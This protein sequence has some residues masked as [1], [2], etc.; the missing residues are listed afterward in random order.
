M[1]S[2]ELE[3]D[4][5][6]LTSEQFLAITCRKKRFNMLKAFSR[7]YIDQLQQRLAFVITHIAQDALQLLKQLGLS[8]ALQARRQ[9]KSMM[10]V[11]ETL[12]TSF[13]APL[14][15]QIPNM[16]FEGAF[17]DVDP[18]VTTVTLVLLD[19]YHQ[20]ADNKR[21]QF[22]ELNSLTRTL[23]DMSWPEQGVS[24][25]LQLSDVLAARLDDY[26]RL[27]GA[28]H[29]YVI[30]AEL[31][32]SIEGCCIDMGSRLSALAQGLYLCVSSSGQSRE[33]RP[34]ES[35]IEIQ[36]LATRFRRLQSQ[37][38]HRNG[39][40]KMTRGPLSAQYVAAVTAGKKV[41]PF[42]S[43][44]S[45]GARSRPRAS[46][47]AAPPQQGRTQSAGRTSMRPGAG[48]PRAPQREAPMPPRYT[49][50]SGDRQRA[51]PPTRANAQDQSH[52]FSQMCRYPS[53]CRRVG[54]KYADTGKDMCLF[55]HNAR[56][57]KG[58]LDDLRAFNASQP[59]YAGQ[60]GGPPQSSNSR[61]RTSSAR[62]SRARQGQPS[63]SVNLM[64]TQGEE[65]P[66]RQF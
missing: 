7:S 37:R 30:M 1:M 40:Q 62:T 39:E 27:G 41:L 35:Y 61:S 46:S 66:V 55:K 36:K 64:T 9:A 45:S 13:P 33:P 58:T 52:N 8:S 10:T 50:S 26:E 51:S 5:G 11:L 18:Q 14:L 65:P 60:V 59:P 53:S 44:S 20:T 23:L 29:F 48:A 4:Q 32:E 3:Y 63:Q 31:Q 38:E 42:S 34:E 56:T 43:N 25:F 17:E 49:F 6:D 15:R 57:D 19:M 16:N 28:H 24:T 12:S 22:H 47:A 21:D 54:R 2:A